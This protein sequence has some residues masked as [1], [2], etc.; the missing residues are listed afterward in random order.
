[1]FVMMFQWL[2]SPFAMP[3]S[4]IHMPPAPSPSPGPGPTP[5]HWRDRPI[6]PAALIGIIWCAS[7]RWNA[8]IPSRLISASVPRLSWVSGQL[9]W[10]L[11]QNR[12]AARNWC[13][14][15]S[16]VFFLH[17]WLSVGFVSKTREALVCCH[18][19]ENAV[20]LLSAVHTGSFSTN[21]YLCISFQ[22]LC[23]MHKIFV[24]SIYM[25]CL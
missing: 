23:K 22:R 7:F 16:G 3:Y 25:L 15:V 5:M 1:M 10:R 8:S 19:E 6:V 18:K 11:H 4:S 21:M 24:V 20:L 14:I 13:W 9:S 2:L 17:S 12:C